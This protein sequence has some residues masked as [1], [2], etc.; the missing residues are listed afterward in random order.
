MPSICFH[1]EADLKSASTCRLAREQGGEISQQRSRCIWPMPAFTHVAI[2][3]QQHELWCDIY[4]GAHC[5]RWTSVFL[6]SFKDHKEL[7]CTLRLD[8]S[9]IMAETVDKAAKS[10]HSDAVILYTKLLSIS[11][12][13]GDAGRP[14]RCCL[15]LNLNRTNQHIFLFMSKKDVCLH[16]TSLWIIAN[17]DLAI[18]KKYA[19]MF[20]WNIEETESE[21]SCPHPG[22]RL[23]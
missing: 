21:I 3:V 23:P 6:Y 12:F 10:L 11:A 5:I 7:L 13:E 18:K 20:E 22:G 2:H 19:E 1:K 15:Q 17:R 16:L 4:L 8:R 14:L 9:N